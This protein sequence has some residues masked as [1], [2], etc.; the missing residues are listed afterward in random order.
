MIEV[1]CKNR[2]RSAAGIRDQID[3]ALGRFVGKA[4]A[5]DDLT[6]VIVKRLE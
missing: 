6:L 3:E 1:V 5:V 2:H 4:K